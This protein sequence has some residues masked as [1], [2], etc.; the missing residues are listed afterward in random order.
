LIRRA[1]ENDLPAIYAL[2][3]RVVREVYSHLELPANLE[4]LIPT[5]DWTRAHVAIVDGAIA[6]VVLVEGE[7]VADLWVELAARSR[8]LGAALLACGVA[9]IA[10]AGHVTGKLRVVATNT[11]AVAFYER[12]GWSRVRQYPHE[13]MPAE[14]IDFEKRL[15]G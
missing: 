9:E 8:G 10:A 6:G 13:K 4:E 2:V 1:E 11:R 3:A 14:M 15:G 5:D 12:E 7:R